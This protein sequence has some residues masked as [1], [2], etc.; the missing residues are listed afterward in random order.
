VRMGEPPPRMYVIGHPAGRDLEISLQDNYLL[1]LD[2]RRLHY[3]TPTEPGSSGSPVFEQESWEVVA[4]HHK[5]AD[6]MPRLG[7]KEGVY[8]ANEGITIPALQQMTRAR[9]EAGDL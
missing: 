9:Q 2:D 8:P 1:D 5:G 7:G 6:D 3:R 4:L